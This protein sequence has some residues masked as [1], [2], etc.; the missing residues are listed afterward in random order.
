ML[1]VCRERDERRMTCENS[2]YKRLVRE[3]ILAEK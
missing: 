2:I 3:S 1:Q